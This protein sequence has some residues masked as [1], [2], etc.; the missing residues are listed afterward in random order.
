MIYLSGKTS[1]YCKVSSLPTVTHG[2]WSPAS[3]VDFK[4]TATLTCDAD[5]FSI[6]SVVKCEHKG[7]F[8]ITAEPNCVGKFDLLAYLYFTRSPQSFE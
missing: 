4:G 6:G 2:S 1:G 8:K 5:Y 3:K 7:E